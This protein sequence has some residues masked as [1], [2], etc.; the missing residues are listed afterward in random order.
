MYVCHALSKHSLRP[1][2]THCK[3]RTW[4][5][6]VVRWQGSVS[7]HAWHWVVHLAGP[8]ARRA[9]VQH[10]RQT[11]DSSIM[12]LSICGIPVRQWN[13]RPAHGRRRG[14]LSECDP[15]S[16]CCTAQLLA[17]QS[18]QQRNDWQY[19]ILEGCSS[20]DQDA[21]CTKRQRTCVSTFESTPSLLPT[22]R[23]SDTAAMDAAT[24]RVL[25]S[26]AMRPA[27]VRPTASMI[28]QR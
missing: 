27:A 8:A 26:R 7:Q 20:V 5:V 9:R 6:A 24:T 22:A 3:Q 10:L 12:F 21:M 11:R 1:C 25:H 23:D 2:R 4:L 13:L 28:T 16:N 17:F 15:L 18:G 14:A 19:A